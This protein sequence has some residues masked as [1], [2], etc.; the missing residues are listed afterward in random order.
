MTLVKSKTQ[1]IT[2]NI[3]NIKIRESQN[4]ELLDLKIDNRLTFKDN[5]NMLCHRANYKL[6][7]LRRIRKYLTLEN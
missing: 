6:Q 4:I 3:S 5:I 1:T 7:S 2:L